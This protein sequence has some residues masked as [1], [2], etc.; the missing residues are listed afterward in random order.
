MTET[1]YTT[2]IHIDFVPVFKVGDPPPAGN[3]YNDWHEWAAAQHK[4]GL[5]Q[6]RCKQCNRFY[7]PQEM[8]RHK[9][10]P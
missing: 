9:C 5:R 7:F 4:G 1:P 3:G 2:G 6:K 8:E 10:Q